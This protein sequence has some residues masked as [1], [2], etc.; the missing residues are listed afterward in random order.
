MRR[1]AAAP[2]APGNLTATPDDGAVALSWTRAEDNGSPI[3]KYQHQR[4]DAPWADIA[5]GAAAN[6][7]RVTGLVNDTRYT[8]SV[9]ALNGMGEGAVASVTAAPQAVL[10]DSE[11]GKTPVPTPEPTPTPEPEE[12]TTHEPTPTPAAIPEPTQR[13][14]LATSTPE[15]PRTPVLTAAMAPLSA[16][17]AVAATPTA[18][19]VAGPTPPHIATPTPGLTA[20]VVQRGTLG[21]TARPSATPAGTPVE[22]TPSRITDSPLVPVGIALFALLIAALAAFILGP[23]RGRKRDRDGE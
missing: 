4:D 11:P 14:V 21:S 8:F 3:I 15:A 18:A 13:A 22:E 20:T 2:D 17:G 19:P 10:A 23:W 7:L 16:G 12:E 6:S 1:P 5:G 9:R